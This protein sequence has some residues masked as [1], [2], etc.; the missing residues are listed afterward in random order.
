M[1]AFRE[2]GAHKNKNPGVSV[3]TLPGLWNSGQDNSVR[4]VL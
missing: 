4:H 3:R 1:P 2:G